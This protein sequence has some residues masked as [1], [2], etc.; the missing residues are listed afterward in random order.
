MHVHILYFKDKHFYFIIPHY[1][2]DLEGFRDQLLIITLYVYSKI[3]KRQVPKTK[4]TYKQTHTIEDQDF[5][6][7]DSYLYL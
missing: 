2:I 3:L 4:Q 1:E 5:Q 6:A 7:W